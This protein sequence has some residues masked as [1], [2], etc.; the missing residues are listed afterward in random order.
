MNSFAVLLCFRLVLFVQINVFEDMRNHPDAA[1]R[2]S[3]TSVAQALREWQQRQPSSAS[4]SAAAGLIPL[5]R[6]RLLASFASS[7]E[8]LAPLDFSSVLSLYSRFDMLLGQRIV[9]M[10]RK[11]EHAESFYEA[12]ATGY[13]P[14]GYLVV[15]TDD[16]Q[17]K[18][19]VAEEVT[20]RPTTTTSNAAAAAGAAAAK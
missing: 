20:I 10:P 8:S 1:L 15:R 3:A 19:L 12:L 17:T 9:V 11:R 13:S 2:E 16:G 7:L 5:S 4:A 18:E 6:E 14:D